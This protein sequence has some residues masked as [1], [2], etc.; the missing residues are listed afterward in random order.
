MDLEAFLEAVL[1]RSD[2]WPVEEKNDSANISNLDLDFMTRHPMLSYSYISVLVVMI[3]GG[4]LGNLVV[5]IL[6]LNTDKQR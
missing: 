2:D 6:T 5:C 3:V 1:E 4:T